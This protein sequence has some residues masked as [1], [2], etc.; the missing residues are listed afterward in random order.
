MASYSVSGLWDALKPRELGALAVKM[1]DR[2]GV[3]KIKN[4][5]RLNGGGGLLTE[6]AFY[7][8]VIVSAIWPPLALT[9]LAG[10]KK[11]EGGVRLTPRVVTNKVQMMGSNA[12]KKR[13]GG[14]APP[15]AR[16]TPTGIGR[17]KG[18]PPKYHGNHGSKKFG[19]R[20]GMGVDTGGDWIITGIF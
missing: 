20:W 18:D 17:N 11:S 14:E 19:S 6:W 7:P 12:K 9:E 1:G 2:K 5:H 15:V 10:P 16:P 13:G 3:L 4:P 8:T